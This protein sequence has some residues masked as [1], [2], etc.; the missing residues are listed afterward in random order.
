M[1]NPISKS[2]QVKFQT[3]KCDYFRLHGNLKRALEYANHG[4]EICKN[5][6]F[7]AAAEQLEERIREIENYPG[8]GN[9]PAESDKLVGQ[10]RGM[11]TSDSGNLESNAVQ[12]SDVGIF[13]TDEFSDWDTSQKQVIKFSL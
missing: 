10:V 13:S 11:I 2:S 8:L 3:L 4:L 5:C 1:C 6:G 7:T 12:P 9:A